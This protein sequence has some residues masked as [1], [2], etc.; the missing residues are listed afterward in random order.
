MKRIA[1]IFVILVTVIGTYGQDIS[2]QW[3]GVLKV[4]GMQLRI[5]FNITKTGNGYSSTMDSP[6][7]GAKGIPVTSTIF[8]KSKLK[9]EITNL[10][11]EY[12]GELKGKIIEGFMK[13]NGMEFPM[14]L[15]Q[16]GNE[17][18]EPLKREDTVNAVFKET[19]IVLH[20]G[21]GQIFGTLTT[22]KTFS[23]IPVTLIIAGSGPTDRDCNSSMMKCD[24]YKKLAFELAENGIASVRYDKRGIGE[25]RAAMK[26]EAELRFDDYVNDAKEWVQLLKQDKRFSK[27]IVIGHSEGS[28]IGMMAASL[29]DQFISIA[30]AGQSADKI[31]KKQL[32]NLPKEMQDISY[33]ILDSLSKGKKVESVNP[34]LLALF[35]PSVQSYMISWFR[36]D[37]QLELAK[38][39]I[40]VLLIQGTNDIQVTT[41][42]A[43][44]LLKAN[45]KSQMSLID[46]MNHIF[47]TVEGDK[48]ANIATYSNPAL[49]LADGFVK[50][51]TVFI[52][53]I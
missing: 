14:N 5:V 47:R 38:L 33:S 29:A 24:A 35:R 52:S 53:K 18:L 45:P 11:F 7:Q 36:Y 28:L 19:P 43:S 21:S 30:G 6:D 41:E 37:P 16:A 26:S 50:I 13:Q 40:P 48:L 44:R 32:G 12:T 8:G 9:L 39:T 22:P 1:A 17:K 23:K 42:D 34:M 49:P 51:I 4:Q 31:I 15:S 3:N 25:S 20:T 10:K 46:K 2:G 27:V